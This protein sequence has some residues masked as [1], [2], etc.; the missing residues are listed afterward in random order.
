[1]IE[2][3]QKPIPSHKKT[4]TRG[5]GYAELYN[6]NRMMSM[7]RVAHQDKQKQ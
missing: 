2:A 5:M 1:M 7:Y 3:K 6:G 4:R